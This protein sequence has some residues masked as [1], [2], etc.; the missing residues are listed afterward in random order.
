MENESN[1]QPLLS[2]EGHPQIHIASLKAVPDIKP[3]KVPKDF[4]SEFWVE[5]KKL[6]PLAGPAIFTSLCQ[7]S[8]SFI[9]QALVG[10]LGDLELAAFSVQYGVTSSFTVGIM[11]GMGSALETLCGQAYGANQLDMMGVYLQRSWIIL[12]TTGLVL[13]PL[14]IF[15]KQLLMA[16]GQNE[17]IS[18]RAGQLAIWMIPQL[19]AYALNY[20]ISKYLQAQSKMLA[21]A[22][23][24]FVVMLI[25]FVL[26]WAFIFKLKWGLF[27]AA[28]AENVSWWLLVLAQL[29]YIFGG[30]CGSAWSGFSWKAFQN[31]WEFVKLS[32]ASA[33]MLCLEVW[34]FTALVLFAGYLKNPKIAVDALSIC[35]S[36]LS[37]VM[38]VA[39]GYNAAIRI[40]SMF[41]STSD[42]PQCMHSVRVSNEL[43]AGHPRTA[44]FSVFVVVAYSFACG[45]LFAL[46]LFIFRNQYAIAFTESNSV[47]NAVYHLT[48]LLVI[49][50]IL[51]TVQP[52]LSGVAIGAGWQAI[53]AYVN[54]GS[55]YVLGVPLGLIFGYK[56]NL[57]VSG[58]W[59]GM[60]VGTV[61]QTA[62]LFI[63]TYTTNW[64]KES[65]DAE[66]RIRKWSGEPTCDDNDAETFSR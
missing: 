36:I 55:Y 28:M 48:P 31:L 47:R 24:S 61:V 54:I 52:V 16:I 33:V 11:I 43:G 14:Y 34:Y 6:W 3:I 18:R 44:K 23:I 30:S 37:W 29:V 38:M 60:I 57:G 62:I 42:S 66:D 35:T 15:S 32:I 56:L 59:W 9:T 65:S 41:T 13:S 20:P 63:L 64:D 39:F 51:N 8:F 2:E 5:S 45:L 46:I 4:F 12:G 53:V 21:M 27:G 10:H 49:S 22:V 17:E 1:L 58:I 25:N 19:F 7:F 50:I 26:S 40:D